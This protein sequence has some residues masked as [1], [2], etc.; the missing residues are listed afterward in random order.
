MGLDLPDRR[1][2]KPRCTDRVSALTSVHQG[3]HD[4]TRPSSANVDTINGFPHARS[5]LDSVLQPLLRISQKHVQSF[6]VGEPGR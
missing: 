3:K 2:I 6:G 4:F 5:D 1:G